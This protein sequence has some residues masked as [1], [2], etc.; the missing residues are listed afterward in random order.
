MQ[1]V[2]MSTK[3]IRNDLEGFLR[4]LKKGHTISVIYRSKPLVTVVAKEEQ[5]N[6]LKS[7]A[8]QPSAAKR[9]V[10]FVRSL[11]PRP[12]SLD[13]NKSFKQLYQET[14]QL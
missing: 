11:P 13:P 12:V 1:T 7:D 9:S 2:V 3:E 5:D 4:S 6:F 10:R 14:H 8:G